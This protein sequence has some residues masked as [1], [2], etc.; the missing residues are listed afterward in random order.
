MSANRIPKKDFKVSSEGKKKSRK[1]FKMVERL[2]HVMPITSLKSPNNGKDDD[3]DDDDI[4]GKLK[5]ILTTIYAFQ[6]G[7]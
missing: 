4:D 1:T 7:L 5:N 6:I 3:D 2:C